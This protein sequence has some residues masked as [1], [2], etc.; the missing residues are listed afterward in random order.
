MIEWTIFRLEHIHIRDRD[1]GTFCRPI[2]RAEG[3]ASFVHCRPSKSNVRP[4]RQSNT[5]A[6]EE[7]GSNRKCEMVAWQDSTSDRKAG[8]IPSQS[9]I[10]T[11]PFP[12]SSSPLVVCEWI[13]LTFL[14][15][16]SFDFLTSQVELSKWMT[17]VHRVHKWEFVYERDISFLNIQH[18]RVKCRLLG[19]Q[20][21][22]GR[23]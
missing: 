4:S 13:D 5:E 18:F 14:V 3:G 7:R 20:T 19:S 9:S 21:G 16:S 22:K 12:L 15:E 1:S 11:R 6:I 23:L 8:S 10:A 2:V 17:A